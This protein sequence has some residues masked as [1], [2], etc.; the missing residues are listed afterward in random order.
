MKIEQLGPPDAHHSTGLILHWRKRL[1]FALEPVQLWREDS[2]G[3][4]TRFVGIGGHLEPGETW[5]EAVCREALEEA[6]LHI[7]LRSPEKTYLL[8]EGGV[9][10]DV[11][12]TLTWSKPPRPLFVWSARHG[13]PPVMPMVDFVNAVFEADVPDDVQPRPAAEMPAILAVHE[14]QLR[15]AALQPVPLDELLAEGAVM[16]GATTIPRS[17]RLQPGGSALWYVVLRDQ[18]GW[19][20]TSASSGPETREIL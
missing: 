20:S 16:W 2:A 13:C 17:I 19:T 10:E 3:P 9:V 4:L 15:Q 14:A 6:T 7:S 12:T 11:T 5:S 8:Q 1:L 18:L